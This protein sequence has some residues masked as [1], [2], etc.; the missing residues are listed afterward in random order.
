MRSGWRIYAVLV[1]ARVL[2]A[3]TSRSIIHP[4]EH[5]QNPEVAARLIFDYAKT[6]TEPLE[7]WEWRADAPC[8]SVAPLLMS[9]APVFY[10]VRAFF[11]PCEPAILCLS[12]DEADEQLQ[13]LRQRLSI[14]HNGPRCSSSRS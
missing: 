3:F 8:R 12:L 7:T 5:F 14:S 4:D 13:I 11:D 6:G 2:I 10:L 1:I 9:T